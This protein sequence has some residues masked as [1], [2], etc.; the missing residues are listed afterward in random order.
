MQQ[1]AVRLRPALL[2]R[3]L[4]GGPPRARCGRGSCRRVRIRTDLRGASSAPK[5]GRGQAQGRVRGGCRD[6]GVRLC[7]CGTELIANATGLFSTDASIGQS[8]SSPSLAPLGSTYECRSAGLKSLEVLQDLSR[9]RGATSPLRT[10]CGGT[11]I[12]AN[13]SQILAPISPN[14]PG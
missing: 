3:V 1:D 5:P 12:R 10:R 9:G 4:H 11:L 8:H 7:R 13:W 6:P 14:E 2:R